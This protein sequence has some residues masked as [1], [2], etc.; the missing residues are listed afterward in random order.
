MLD[1][2]NKESSEELG[3]DAEC[4]DAVDDLPETNRVDDYNNPNIP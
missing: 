2:D 1:K 3:S 4:E